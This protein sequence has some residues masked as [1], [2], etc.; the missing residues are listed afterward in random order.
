MT[1][2]PEKA[3]ILHTFGFQVGSMRFDRV[4]GVPFSAF[5]LR[6]GSGF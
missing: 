4:S 6:V 3:I 2:N 1:H 5:L